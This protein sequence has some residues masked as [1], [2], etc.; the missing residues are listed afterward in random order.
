MKKLKKIATLATATTLSAGILFSILPTETHAATNPKVVQAQNNL[1]KQVSSYIKTLTSYKNAI[2]S[3]DQDIHDYY[4]ELRTDLTLFTKYNYTNKDGLVKKIAGYKTRIEKAR[5]D[6]AAIDM[7][8]VTAQF[9]TYVKK[10]DSK[11]AKTYF[12]TQKNKLMAIR[13]YQNHTY[14]SIEEYVYEIEDQIYTENEVYIRQKLP[15]EYKN[16]EVESDLAMQNLYGLSSKEHDVLNYAYEVL[17]M[18]YS[19]HH[20]IET[21]IDKMFTKL[22][23]ENFAAI[24]DLEE[25]EDS[26]LYSAID[27]RDVTKAKN[28]LVSGTAVYKKFNDAYNQAEAQ[29]E[30]YKANLTVKFASKVKK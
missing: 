9:N 16:F 2:A 10:V 25:D 8:K 15:V 26:S 27:N 4:M 23:N 24:D 11:S 6:N 1:K 22:F 3:D 20:Q 17:N 30:A 21:D 7:K 19:T 29:L 14:D 13:N 28:A 5:K 18:D 12:T